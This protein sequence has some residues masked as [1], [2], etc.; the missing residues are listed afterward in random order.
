MSTRKSIE[1][2]LVYLFQ[3]YLPIRL[4]ELIIGYVSPQCALLYGK[5]IIIEFDNLIDTVH[6]EPKRYR[7]FEHIFG[8]CKLTRGYEC[9]VAESPLIDSQPYPYFV[10]LSTLYSHLV[11]TG[12][13]EY[14]VND[15]NSMY[16]M[17]SSNPIESK[18]AIHLEHIN[19][20]QDEDECHRIVQ[21]ATTQ[22]DLICVTQE[23]VYE[24]GETQTIS[25]SIYQLDYA[26]K[27]WVHEAFIE[28]FDTALGLCGSNK[29]FV[30]SFALYLSIFNRITKTWHELKFN[31]KTS[32]ECFSLVHMIVCDDILF[33]FPTEF[34]NE[35]LEIEKY[36]LSELCASYQHKNCSK[37]SRIT[38]TST[39]QSVLL[40]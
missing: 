31:R 34:T 39:L 4:T 1:A 38:N 12:S 30:V 8:I 16:I 22:D 17:S 14:D 25:T 18:I 40:Y 32:C 5:S 23:T 33:L 37:R 24:A 20:N 2:G 36:D 26:N 3:E 21:Y 7:Y 9:I 10:S 29:W 19:L 13:D 15:M 11:F 27:C 35:I 6:L 28:Q